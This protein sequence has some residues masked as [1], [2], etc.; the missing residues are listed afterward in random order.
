MFLF[1]ILTQI[2]GQNDLDST[3]KNNS[4][5]FSV[6]FSADLVKIQVRQTVCGV[7]L[8]RMDI[9]IQFWHVV[10]VMR[11]DFN[12]HHITQVPP[13]ENQLGEMQMMEEV[14]EHVG[15]NYPETPDSRYVAQPFDDFLF[16]WEEES[17]DNPITIEEDE[18]FSEPRTPVS[19]PLLMKA[20][21]ALRSIENL[22]NF[23]NSDARQLFD[24]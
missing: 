9:P 19:K 16:P 11:R 10:E 7:F 22:Q 23:E 2:F 12:K 17:V 15:M 3:K 24:L 18:G 1:C 20:R 21:P 6:E 13:T 4:L 8:A 5:I 14:A